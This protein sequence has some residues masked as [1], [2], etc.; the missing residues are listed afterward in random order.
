MRAKA[1]TTNRFERKAFLLGVVLLVG[2]G[3]LGLVGLAQADQM[4]PNPTVQM[5]DNPDVSCKSPMPSAEETGQFGET[6]T[7]SADDPIDFVVVKTAPNATV[8]FDSSSG[9][10]TSSANILGYVVFT[11]PASTTTTDTT[12]TDTTT[13]DTT[14]TDTTTTDTTTT[15]T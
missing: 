12:T 3:T 11:C 4:G 15:D 14:T 13:T 5:V 6:I 10:I 9:Q 2:L 7:V 1:K 8:T